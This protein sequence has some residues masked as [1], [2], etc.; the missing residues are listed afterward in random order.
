M[1]TAGGA[2]FAGPGDRPWLPLAKSNVMP[3]QFAEDSD[4]LPPGS[5][6]ATADEINET[7]VEAF[8]ASRTRKPIF[9]DWS[10][11]LPTMAAAV[12]LH[13]Q[14]IHG[15]YVTAKLDP[16]DVDLL[17]HYD[18]PKFDELDPGARDRFNAL[19]SGKGAVAPRCDSLAIAAYPEGHEAREQY[20][21]LAGP[22]EE[23]C[24]SDRNG[25]PRGYID[26]QHQCLS[27]NRIEIT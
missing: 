22:W 8:P 14:W 13:R 1:E 16:G 19:I 20:L 15:S 17:S 12:P 6:T 5:H 10:R 23:M 7:L 4:I 11:L 25:R 26:L 27:P 21:L 24:G 2:N 3:I 18:G 9:G